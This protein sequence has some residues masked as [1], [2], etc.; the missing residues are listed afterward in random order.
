MTIRKNPVLSAVGIILLTALTHLNTLVV[1]PVVHRLRLVTDNTVPALF[2][3]T[4]LAAMGVTMEREIQEAHGRY[5]NPTKTST[6]VVYAT[7]G[8]ALSYG[9]ITA[10]ITAQVTRSAHELGFVG[11]SFV[12]G[13]PVPDNAYLPTASS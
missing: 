10:G 6:H 1:M 9:D 12:I 2:K 7:G 11:K 13:V 3:M 4:D 5:G 8:S